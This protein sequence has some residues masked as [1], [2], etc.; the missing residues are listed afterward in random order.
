MARKYEWLCRLD[1]WQCNSTNAISQISL[2]AKKKKPKRHFEEANESFIK[3]DHITFYWC[4]F[5][6]KNCVFFLKNILSANLKTARKWNTWNFF[7]FC[8]FFFF[9]DKVDCVILIYSKK[10]LFLDKK[11]LYIWCAFSWKIS[12][13][14]FS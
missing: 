8:N 5:F 14:N 13:K 1:G 6:F 10:F 11:E 12:D 7:L 3:L 4:F 2:K 9:L